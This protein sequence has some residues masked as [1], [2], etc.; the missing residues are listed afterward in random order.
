MQSCL[1]NM[2]SN[3]VESRDQL[4]SIYKKL[5]PAAHFDIALSLNEQVGELATFSRDQSPQ[6]SR[7]SSI[8][9][10]DNISQILRPLTVNPNDK[11]K[12]S[13]INYTFCFGSDQNTETSKTVRSININK[14]SLDRFISEIIDISKSRRL[15]NKRPPLQAKYNNRFE[16]IEG[17]KGVGKTHL[18][19]YIMSYYSNQFDKNRIIWVRINLIRN[20][21]NN[22]NIDI[23]YW[24]RCQMSKILLRYYDINS[25]YYQKKDISLT[26]DW[27]THLTRF[28]QRN[29]IHGVEVIV[30]KLTRL[31]TM[32]RRLQEI[33]LNQE[34]SSE[35]MD[36]DLVDEIYRTAL[37]DLEISP[38]FIVDGI[39]LL[40][41]Q[42]SAKIRYTHRI[43]S[44]EKYLSQ[45]DGDLA[46]SLIFMRPKTFEQLER[47]WSQHIERNSIDEFPI[48]RNVC[49]CN[50]EEIFK[51]RVDYLFSIKPSISVSFE[52]L[53]NFVEF[54]YNENSDIKS[55]DGHFLKWI[56][57][58]RSLSNG[59]ARL[60]TQFFSALSYHFE[61]SQS[62]LGGGIQHRYQFIEEA[63][64]GKGIFPPKSYSYTRG[65]GRRLGRSIDRSGNIY[66]TMFLPSIFYFPYAEDEL[67]GEVFGEVGLAKIIWPLRIIQAIDFFFNVNRSRI[68]LSSLCDLL[69][70][71]FGYSASETELILDELSAAEVID[72]IPDTLNMTHWSIIH[73]RARLTTKGHRILH[74]F[75]NDV[76]YLALSSYTTPFPRSLFGASLDGG[77]LF[78]EGSPRFQAVDEWI[79][80]KISN[81][82][83]MLKLIVEAEKRQLDL[84][85]ANK[86]DISSRLAKAFPA[87]EWKELIL[88]SMGLSPGI[89]DRIKDAESDVLLSSAFA[90]NGYAG[91]GDEKVIVKRL[92]TW[93]DSSA[94]LV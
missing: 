46:Y 62:K 82:L 89:F 16:I 29:N 81:G 50:I 19:N 80:T 88:A 54:V 53:Q 94:Q 40:T 20:F 45:I 28:V 56:E 72:V 47:T 26:F 67:S 14:E 86:E 92:R 55:E 27:K 32:I 6:S 75:I 49:S 25:K 58:I 30:K 65:T 21:G 23:R 69:F 41:E 33:G 52:K 44:L 77:L 4:K 42:K 85:R 43:V 35:W 51:K 22:N 76:S 12:T 90:I 64:I 17:K 73:Y 36:E 7:L 74:S 8:W 18:Q 10:G 57:I 84:I 34:I 66:D 70:L 71:A 78:R 3:D 11:D 91:Y 60:A 59:N 1:K 93:V 61:D 37:V 13:I 2:G 5:N 68:L 79:F 39:D 63:M 15:A 38:I 9:R 31:E 24:L 87:E 83:M 48:R